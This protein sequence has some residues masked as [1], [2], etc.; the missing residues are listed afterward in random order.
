[1]RVSRRALGL[2]LE[3]VVGFRGYP[4]LLLIVFWV[5]VLGSTKYCEGCGALRL[6]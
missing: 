4:L 2:L 5:S 3:G 6:Q 1:M